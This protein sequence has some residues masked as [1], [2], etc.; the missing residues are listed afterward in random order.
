MDKHIFELPFEFQFGSVVGN[1]VLLT[2]VCVCPGGGPVWSGW[3]SS[4]CSPLAGAPTKWRKLF[5]KRRWRSS[6]QARRPSKH[7]NT[8]ARSMK[9]CCEPRT[10]T[11]T[12][13]GWEH[14]P[15]HTH[16]HTASCALRQVCRMTNGHASCV[17][18]LWTMTGVCQN[19]TARTD[20]V[21]RPRLHTHIIQLQGPQGHLS[22]DRSH[23][24]EEAVLQ[25]VRP[26][27]L[28]PCYHC[29][30]IL[31]VNVDVVTVPLI[32]NRE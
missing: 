25:R 9:P 2:C 8:Y 1:M 7:S 16:N 26:L 17:D 11:H 15:T 31:C 29:T 20:Y 21:E 12:H 13:N 32:M 19:S 4:V 6:S 14:R 27:P 24:K 3:W 18:M 10:H 28:H 23:C 22:D 30:F 5:I